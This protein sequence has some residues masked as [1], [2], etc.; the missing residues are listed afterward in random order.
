ILPSELNL[1][2]YKGSTKDLARRILEHSSGRTISTGR[3]APWVLEWFAPKSTKQEAVALEL[4][5]KNLLV[6]R[7]INFIKNRYAP[8][9]GVFD[10][11]VIQR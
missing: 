7:T 6:E 3:Y 4:K 2:Y 11:Q 10:V 1:S 8:P 5:L 9:V